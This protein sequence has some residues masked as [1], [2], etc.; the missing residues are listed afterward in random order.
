MKVHSVSDQEALVEAWNRASAAGETQA[1]FCTGKQIGTRTLR[2][3]VRRH[4]PDAP[5]IEVALTIVDRALT[6]LTQLRRALADRL[7][8]T[9]F[10]ERSDVQ[11]PRESA[12]TTPVEPPEASKAQTPVPAADFVVP[13]NPVILAG[14]VAPTTPKVPFNFDDWWD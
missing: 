4:A 9:P 8:G 1:A 11:L 12:S 14:E 3:Y 6:D 5:P 2:R 13:A 10:H 7:A